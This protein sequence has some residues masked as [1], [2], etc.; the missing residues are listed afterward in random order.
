MMVRI[1]LLVVVALVSGKALAQAP[2]M[3]CSGE[4]P[5]I[6]ASTQLP[7]RVLVRPFSN[8]YETRSDG[9]DEIRVEGA[10]ALRPFYVFDDHEVDYAST[11]RDRSGWFQ[12]GVTEARPVGWVRAQ[13]AFLWKQALVVAY[14]HPGS[15]ESGRRPV[16][17]FNEK[18]ALERVVF[19]QSRIADSQ[20]LYRSLKSGE[21]PENII[22]QEPEG[23]FL[24]IDETFYLFP[25]T[26]WEM[27]EEFDEPGR[28]LELVA[29]V[30]EARAS[31]ESDY[32][33]LDPEFNRAESEAERA[34]QL[35]NIKVD[36][37]FALDLTGS[38]QPHLDRTKDAIVSLAKG[39]SRRPEV[40]DQ[41][42]FGFV[43]FRDDTR[44]NPNNEFAVRNFTP[45]L[46]DVNELAARLDKFAIAHD[47]DPGWEEEVYAG[48]R[49]AVNAQW[50]TERGVRMVILVGDASANPP[51]H[52]MSTTGLDAAAV[53]RLATQADV[54]VIAIYLQQSRARPDW[55]RAE[56]QFSIMARNPTTDAPNFRA[57]P[58]GDRA[59]YEAA[60]SDI[61]TTF[62]SILDGLVAGRGEEVFSEV[63][64]DGGAGEM[65]REIM[66]GA[67]IDYLG[68]TAEPPVD[69]TFWAFDRDLEEPYKDALSVRLLISRAQLNDLVISLETVLEALS[70]GDVGEVGF[71]KTLQGIVAK[72]VKADTVSFEDARDLSATGLLPSWIESLPYRSRILNLNDGLI[73]SLT[74]DDRA[75]LESDVRGMIGLYREIL[76]DSDGWRKL[77][78]RDASLD[79]V[80]PLPLVNLP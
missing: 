61:L 76:E 4:G 38:M 7:V 64:D 24:D 78:A 34:G 73:E 59:A 75:R 69:V 68:D 37:V 72:S 60:A 71:I 1:F 10:P 49:E 18:E 56:R 79:A 47:G 41:I 35:A 74:A 53:R 40:T 31:G 9:P 19:S 50:A 16:L 43:G 55:R 29:A 51:G 48:M 21:R 67:L 32:T 28:M 36:V 42:R 5:C 52:P 80:Y 45:Q 27:V 57:I 20:A 33:I 39:L 54:N 58:A 44:I 25:I 70:S 77:N 23:E 30:P 11:A 46:V 2:E 3:N 15:G 13:D 26:N 14:T 17:G 65:V 63:K 12:V 62:E 6:E 8:I 22:I 66:R